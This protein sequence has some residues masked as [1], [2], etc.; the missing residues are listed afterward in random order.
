MIDTGLKD[1]LVLLSGGNTP[2][3]IG[4]ATAKAFAFQGAAVFIHYSRQLVE[5]IDNVKDGNDFD[6]PKSRFKALSSLQIM[7][8]SS[9]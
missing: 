6:T 1:K 9:V 4:A 5:L 2:H 3:G 8:G 7:M